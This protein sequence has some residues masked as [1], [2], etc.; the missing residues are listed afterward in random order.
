VRKSGGFGIAL[1]FLLFGASIL[2]LVAINNAGVEVSPLPRWAMLVVF[3]GFA[4]MIVGGYRVIVG[5]EPEDA[6]SLRRIVLGVA[7]GLFALML[8]LAA[9]VIAVIVGEALKRSLGQR[10]RLPRWPIREAVHA[11][12]SLWIEVDEVRE[13][14]IEVFGV[15]DME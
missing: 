9:L 10:R 5:R 2:L 4:F 8:L 1:G 7:G 3:P 6:S 14:L 15:A 11:A 13:H 12:H